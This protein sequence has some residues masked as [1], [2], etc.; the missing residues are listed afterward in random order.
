M[1]QSLTDHFLLFNP[2]LLFS[3]RKK[4]TKQNND[5]DFLS[6]EGF[7]FKRSVK[8]IRLIKKTKLSKFDRKPIN[9]VIFFISLAFYA[10]K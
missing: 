10:A 9:D 3:F 7:H 5:D 1:G 2:D 6:E 4:I 8:R